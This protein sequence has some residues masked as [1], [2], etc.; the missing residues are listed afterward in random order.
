MIAG[1][2]AL[3]YLTEV[4]QTRGGHVTI[5]LL[6]QTGLQLGGVFVK[7][8]VRLFPTKVP[9][10]TCFFFTPSPVSRCLDTARRASP[11]GY[12]HCEDA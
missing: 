11:L 5:I 7:C 6:S 8:G 3:A 4:G 12:T 1:R 2:A 9:P 10:G